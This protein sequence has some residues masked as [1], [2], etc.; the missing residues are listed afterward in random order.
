MAF[1][2]FLLISSLSMAF[3]K[4]QLSDSPT[5][6]QML[7]RFNFP[8]GILPEGVRSYQLRQDGSF[9][10][11]LSS[12]CEFEVSGKYLL[13]YKRKIA[14]KVQSGSLE[15]LNGV[16]VKVLFLWI[17]IDK[18][19]RNGDELSFYVGPLSASF[20]TDNF[21]ECPECRCG[22]DCAAADTSLVSE[23]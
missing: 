20:P 23:C 5:A 19:Q 8:R 6:Y 4:T 11:Y 22:F 2:V 9:E 15:E 1:L 17:G 10:V 7:E 12:D 13:R 14:G 16:S 21:D 18:V 3:A